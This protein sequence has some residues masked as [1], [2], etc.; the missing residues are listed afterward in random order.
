VPGGSVINDHT[1][2][3][4]MIPA[5]EPY[6]GHGRVVDAG[7]RDDRRSPIHIHVN[8][9]Q[10][11]SVNDVPYRAHGQQEIVNIPAR[12]VPAR[13]TRRANRDRRR[14]G[15]G[16]IERPSRGRRGAL[17]YGSSIRDTPC[18]MPY[19]ADPHEQ[20]AWRNARRDIERA[21][22]EPTG[23]AATRGGGGL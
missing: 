7:E 5:A 15:Q 20:V 3:P 6:V 11:M 2:T 10:V 14:E 17:V 18:H 23:R 12:T 21:R 8:R 16:R 9:F 1:F 13:Q 4:N 19:P 22:R